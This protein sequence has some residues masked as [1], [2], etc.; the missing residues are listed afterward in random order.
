MCSRT[1]LSLTLF[2]HGGALSCHNTVAPNPSCHRSHC[3]ESISEFTGS[4]VIYADAT[5]N[6]MCLT[7]ICGAAQIKPTH[8]QNQG[9]NKSSLCN[10][11]R[12]KQ[13]AWLSR[14]DQNGKPPSGVSYPV[15][16][17][18]PSLTL[19]WE[20]IHCYPQELG[21]IFLLI[22]IILASVLLTGNYVNLCFVIFSFVRVYELGGTQLK[23]P[24]NTNLEKKVHFI[25]L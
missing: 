8:K 3:K 16:L 4:V 22:C 17:T 13:Q 10:W 7:D 11:A 6:K 12:S 20:Q 21:D 18:L 24:E 9:K 19:S 14:T 2:P 1:V 5:Q 25:F 15:N 23:V